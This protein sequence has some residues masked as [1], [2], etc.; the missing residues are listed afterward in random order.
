MVDRFKI[1]VPLIPVD[2]FKIYVPLI[3]VDRFKIYV[4]LI[5]DP[6]VDRVFSRS[7]SP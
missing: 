3:P 1:Y 2:R 4:P 6:M 5:P 7:S